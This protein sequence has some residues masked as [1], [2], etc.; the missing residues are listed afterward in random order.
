MITQIPSKTLMKQG[1]LE[2]ARQQQRQLNQ[3]ERSYQEVWQKDGV[4]G[5][6]GNQASGN[7]M[8]SKAAH[9]LR[10]AVQN[11]NGLPYRSDMAENGPVK[12][13]FYSTQ[14]NAFTMTECFQHE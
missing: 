5:G 2:V 10:I 7:E 6:P 12:D 13:T 11:L 1:R 3:G 14:T 4:E 9:K 8:L